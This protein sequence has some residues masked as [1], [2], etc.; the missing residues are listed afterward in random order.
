MLF[1]FPD[2]QK[3]L[4]TLKVKKLNTIKWLIY[5]YVEDEVYSNFVLHLQCYFIF[6]IYRGKSINLLM[7]KK[8]DVTHTCGREVIVNQIKWWIFSVS[9]LGPSVCSQPTPR[10]SPTVIIIV[11]KERVYLSFCLYRFLY[12]VQ[13]LKHGS[14]AIITGHYEVY[15]RNVKLTLKIHLAFTFIS[16]AVQLTGVLT[17]WGSTFTQIF[18][19]PYINIE[20]KQRPPWTNFTHEHSVICWAPHSR[21]CCLKPED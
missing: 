3:M 8:C 7:M 12:S 19:C 13:G 20:R 21:P 15:K 9:P 6:R 1:L 14:Y 11:S 2:I 18:I 17:N 5:G 10:S 16:V 4:W